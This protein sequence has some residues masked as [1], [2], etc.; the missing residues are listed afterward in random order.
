MHHVFIKVL[1]IIIFIIIH[2]V[3]HFQETLSFKIEIWG[4]ATRERK[5]NLVE[6]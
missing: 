2:H 6:C 5:K 1:F 4:R 3:E